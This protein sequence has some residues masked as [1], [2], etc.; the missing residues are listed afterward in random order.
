MRIRHAFLLSAAALLAGTGVAWTLSHRHPSLSKPGPLVTRTF[1]LDPRTKSE[2]CIV[3]GPFPD[4]ACTPG[5]VMTGATVEHVCTPG[6]AR[7][8]RNVPQSKKNAVYK[9]YDIPS[10][11][12]G[13]YEVDHFISLE[14]GG[15]ND[16]ANLFPEAASP[17]PGFRE[18]DKVEN[19]LHQQVCAGAISLPDAQRQIST[20]WL[21]VYINEVAP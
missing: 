14:L 5:A 10:H 17:Q 3:Q 12:P 19:Y 7:S 1:H 9:E 13:Q 20:D 16:I 8:V 21:S 11:V 2:H 4:H 18:K 6:Y 15:S